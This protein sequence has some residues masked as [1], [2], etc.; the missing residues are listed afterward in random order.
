M[1]I[2]FKVY[3][4]ILEFLS[5]KYTVENKLDIKQYN[6]I[7]D[8]KGFCIVKS[9]KGA[10]I[11]SILIIGIDNVKSSDIIKMLN[12][13]HEKSDI[14]TVKNNK[15]GS[16]IVNKIYELRGQIIYKNLE[17]ICFLVDIRKHV[18]VPKHEIC[19][20]KEK[21][22]VKLENYITSFANIPHIFVTDPQI[23]WINGKVG[24]LI[25]ITRNDYHGN[26]LTYRIVIPN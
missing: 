26:I 20:E 19:S 6:E 23:V 4:N 24:D 13:I 2:G 10:E 12:H 3:S 18:L 8:D 9:N 15:L 11:L 25:K 16:N 14:Y 17:S 21:E 1:S 5:I 7:M 22:E